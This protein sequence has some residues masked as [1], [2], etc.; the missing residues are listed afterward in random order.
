M[1][2][3]ELIGYVRDNTPDG[4]RSNVSVWF[5]PCSELASVYV[6]RGSMVSAPQFSS[7]MQPPLVCAHRFR[8]WLFD[9]KRRSG[10]NTIHNTPLVIG[11]AA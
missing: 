6:M 1:T 4:N 2:T 9:Y 3:E 7:I 10:E 8:E 11:G 5:E